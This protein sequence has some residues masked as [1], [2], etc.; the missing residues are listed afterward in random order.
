M[1][2]DGKSVGLWS[3]IKFRLWLE[4]KLLT[5]KGRKEVRGILKNWAFG[6]MYGSGGSPLFPVWATDRVRRKVNY[7]VPVAVDLETYRKPTISGRLPRERINFALPYGLGARETPMTEEEAEKIRNFFK[8]SF[9]NLFDQP[10]LPIVHNYSEI[11]HRLME[12]VLNED[13][14][15]LH[16][17]LRRKYAP[18]DLKFPGRE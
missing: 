6:Y 13:P 10:V 8:S 9:P 4:W 7:M 17:L 14:Q 2:K 15:D 18:K 5:K 16:S 12:A 1:A 3:R 11:E